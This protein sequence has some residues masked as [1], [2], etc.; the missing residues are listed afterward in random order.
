MQLIQKSVF[1]VQYWMHRCT[2][3]LYSRIST[4]TSIYFG[5]FF[6]KL[7]ENNLTHATNQKRNF[8]EREKMNQLRIMWDTYTFESRSDR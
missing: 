4:Q 8:L 6:R 2:I 1:V 5:V 7:N 3:P